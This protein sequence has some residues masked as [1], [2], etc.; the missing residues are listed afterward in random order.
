MQF[1]IDQYSEK[2]NFHQQ[3]LSLMHSST[4]F[5]DEQAKEWYP[6]S[7]LNLFI[8]NCNAYLCIFVNEN[9]TSLSEFRF[10]VSLANFLFPLGKHLSSKGE[11]IEPERIFQ[12]LVFKVT[13]INSLFLC[14]MSWQRKRTYFS[15]IKFTWIG[16]FERLIFT[17][18]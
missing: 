18:Y 1:N 14:F 17:S 9:Y 16:N 8:Y 4:S 7:S 6:Y 2:G 10:S 12:T 3:W 15:L 13:L 11:S 5:L